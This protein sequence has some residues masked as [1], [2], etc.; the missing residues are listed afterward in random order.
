MMSVAI[1]YEQVSSLLEKARSSSFVLGQKKGIALGREK[2]E[3]GLVCL[4]GTS[5]SGMLVF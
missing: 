1:R 5:E 3:L 4:R 2:R